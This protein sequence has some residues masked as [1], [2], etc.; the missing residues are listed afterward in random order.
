MGQVWFITGAGRGI[1]AHIARAALQAGHRVVATGRKLAQLHA[2]FADI[3]PESIALVELD[4]SSEA[5]AQE[6]V[7]AAVERF[8]RIDV[9]VNN[10]GYGQL[11]YFEE[12]SA[13]A[14]E[15]QFATN[16]FG[17]MHVLRAALPVMRRQRAGHVFNL[18][19]VGGALGYEGSSIYCASKFA[20]EGLSASV[21]LEVARFGIKVTVVEP[22]FFRTDFLDASSIRYGDQVLDAYADTGTERV[23]Y[24]AYNHRQ[25]GDPA[26]LG[27]AL[28][29]LAAMAEPPRQFLAGSDAVAVIGESL[30]ARLD[31]IHVFAEL[32]RSLDGEF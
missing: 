29:R 22:G 6:A 18:S 12:I 27:A 31:E 24:E 21:A 20:V 3:A 15:R 2:A 8:G 5:Q 10:A 1:G 7:Q 9:L 16:V 19:S 25:S 17:L 26:K 23:T 28:V 13:G 14:V 30:Q 11:G 4:V 32:S